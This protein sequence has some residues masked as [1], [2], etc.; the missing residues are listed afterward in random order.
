MK[1]HPWVRPFGNETAMAD[2]LQYGNGKRYM[3]CSC[4]YGITV[5]EFGE[6]TLCSTLAIGGLVSKQ[7]C[8]LARFHR[9][10]R[11]ELCNTLY[12]YY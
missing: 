12:L 5:F 7:P 2:V 8:S 3:Y 6:R 1:P 10:E 4:D 9:L 11:Q